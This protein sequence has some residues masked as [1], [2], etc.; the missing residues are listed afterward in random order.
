MGPRCLQFAVTD[1]FWKLKLVEHCYILRPV[2]VLLWVTIDVV[3]HQRGLPLEIAADIQIF[4][5]VEGPLI[6]KKRKSN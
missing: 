2:K 6:K 5:T 1:F 4:Y 3:V